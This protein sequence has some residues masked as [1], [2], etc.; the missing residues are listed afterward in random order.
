MKYLGLDLGEKTLGV[1]LSD[2]IGITHPY[3]TLEFHSKQYIETLK[4]LSKIISE[5]EIDEIVVGL[6]T[7]MDNTEGEKVHYV[8]TFVSKLEDTYP[9]KPIHLEDERLTTMEAYELMSEMKFKR[10]EERKLYSDALSA[11]LILDSYLER[12][13]KNEK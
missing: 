4:E 9:S 11:K 2:S 3:K 8:K 13:K 6:P 10:K 7:N 5:Y 1:A 12:I